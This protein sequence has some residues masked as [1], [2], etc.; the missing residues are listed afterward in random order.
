MLR[1][2]TNTSVTERQNIG[3]YVISLCFNFLC[4]IF[5]AQKSL[6][7]RKT[8]GYLCVWGGDGVCEVSSGGGGGEGHPGVSV[9][10]TMLG[11][12]KT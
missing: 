3:G 12:G 11:M 10:L 2:A 4:A 6:P 5:Q 9:I 1:C 7:L 8:V